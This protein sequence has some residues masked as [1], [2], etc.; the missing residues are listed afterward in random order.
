MLRLLYRAVERVSPTLGQLIRDTY[1]TVNGWRFNDL[2]RH[3]DARFQVGGTGAG[4]VALA[5]SLDVLRTQGSTAKPQRRIAFVSNMPPENTGLASCSFYSW[6]GHEGAVDIFCPVSD[7]DWFTANSLMLASP[8]G[9][10]GVRLL[11]VGAFLS[12]DQTNH[13]DSIV[14]AIGNSDSCFYIHDLLKKIGAFG[15][16]ERCVLYVHDPCLLNLVQRGT[17]I[18]AAEMAS[19]FDVIYGRP[20]ADAAAPGAFDWEVHEELVAR[21]AL[22]ARWFTSLGIKQF[23]VNSDAA[24]ALLVTDLDGTDATV[25]K[26]FH[27]AFLPLGAEAHAARQRPVASCTGQPMITVG[28]FGVPSASKRTQDIVKAV[29]HIQHGGQP[30]RLLIAGFGVSAYAKQNAK[31]LAGITVQL[32]DGPT[33]LQLLDCMREVDVAVQLRS[34]NLG[35]SSGVVPQLLQLCKPTV[36]SALGSFAEFGD[37]VASL[38]PEATYEDIASAIL[39]A[40]KD[41]PRVEAMQVYTADR[42]PKR[43]RE[44]LLGI[45]DRN[46]SL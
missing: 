2:K 22:G 24:E 37:A 41:P 32:F 28:T 1:S 34:R 3:V 20:L 27:P 15:G 8:S 44:V 13:Y 36:V 39:A 14:V 46:R 25:R 31:L 26:I 18:S 45:L 11:D 33:D 23:L 42:S 17:Q 6:L 21:G 43:F 29:Q 7:L 4:A 10:I 30:A 19:V 16:I 35:E 40:A 5:M 38:S 12:A 9:S